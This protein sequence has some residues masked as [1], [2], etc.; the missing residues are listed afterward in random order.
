MEAIRRGFG[1]LRQAAAMAAKDP[2]LLKP[3]FFSLAAGAV[4]SLVGAVPMI[5]LYLLA[6]SDTLG[7]ISIFLAGALLI[8]AQ[9]ASAYL[10]S[11]MTVR[12]VHDYLTQGDGRMDLAWASARKNFFRIITLALVSTLVKIVEGF[13]RGNRRGTRGL[14]GGALA[15]LLNAVWT[16][17]TYFVLPAMILEELD[18]GQALKR[19]TQIIKDNLLLVAV[20]E[21]GVGTVV[22]LIGFLLVL[23]AVALGVGLFLLV[24]EL[25]SWSTLSIVLG[26]GGAIL[27]AGVLVTLVIG[28]SSY[29]NTA[30]HTCLFV[31][32]QEV[33][34]ARS[35]GTANAS[36]AAPAPL[37]A[38]L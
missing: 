29:I 19:A 38:V 17:A 32:A 7:Q 12:L 33:E 10:F 1:F 5:I 28:F 15:G 35:S 25:A 21:V 8:F 23:L 6:G 14:I 3:T 16:T 27:I 13:L 30:Y 20:S 11:G 26:T 37:A 22:G 18:L 2:D 24:G 31:W 34:R 9:F 36:A 4:I